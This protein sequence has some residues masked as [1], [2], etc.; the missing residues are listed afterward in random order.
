MHIAYILLHL[1]RIINIFVCHLKLT[2]DQQIITAFSDVASVARMHIEQLKSALN[3]LEQGTFNTWQPLVIAGLPDT[4][5][6]KKIIRTG[7]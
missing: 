4:L 2:D 5:D 1:I 3:D 6:V 7:I